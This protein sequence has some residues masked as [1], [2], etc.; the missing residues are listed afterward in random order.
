MFKHECAI[1]Y[2]NRTF[3]AVDKG[4]NIRIFFLP[5]FSNKIF[6][7]FNFQSLFSILGVTRLVNGEQD[8][9]PVHHEE[10]PSLYSG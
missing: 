4:N 2:I 9:P 5:L 8:R 3:H 6:M 10:V 1:Q 7:H